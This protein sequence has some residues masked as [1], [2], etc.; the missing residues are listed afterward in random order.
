MI[1]VK[2]VLERNQCRFIRKK[3]MTKQNVIRIT[4]IVH[5]IYKYQQN[6]FSTPGIQVNF[7]SVDIVGNLV[8][9]CYFLFGV[10]FF[11][12]STLIIV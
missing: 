1:T 9:N 12:N 2:R 6:L 7:L 3:I 11:T 4:N 8:I 5:I 10:Y